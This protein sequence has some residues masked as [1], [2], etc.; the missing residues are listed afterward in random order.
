MISVDPGRTKIL[1]DTAN[2]EGRAAPPVDILA[3][4]IPCPVAVKTDGIALLNNVEIP[5][6]RHTV[7]GASLSQGHVFTSSVF[8]GQSVTP[9]I[10]VGELPFAAWD[11][12]RRI[13]PQALVLCAV[14]LAFTTLP[15]E[16]SNHETVQ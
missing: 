16:K 8:T 9:G 6:R 4:R 11:R 5:N 1:A 14:A 12:R 10:A 3:Q 15:L 7:F 2:V 13:R